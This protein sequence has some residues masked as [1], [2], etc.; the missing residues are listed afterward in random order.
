[1]KHTKRLRKSLISIMGGVL[2]LSLLLAPMFANVYAE[3]AGT[4]TVADVSQYVTN[5]EDLINGY[6]SDIKLVQRNYSN[7][8]TVYE[9]YNISKQ[10]EKNSVNVLDSIS[11]PVDGYAGW[12]AVYTNDKRTTPTLFD[13]D[14]DTQLTSSSNS[15]KVQNRNDYAGNYTI[16]AYGK[17]E[18]YPTGFYF[19]HNANTQKEVNLISFRSDCFNV[20]DNKIC[21]TTQRNTTNWMGSDNQGGYT[22]TLY[23]DQSTGHN[24]NTSD[25]YGGSSFLTISAS[26]N[27]KI[28]V[29]ET[30]TQKQVGDWYGEKYDLDQS[31][32]LSAGV[33]SD[34]I[35]D[36][37]H[38]DVWGDQGTITYLKYTYGTYG[39]TDDG[40]CVYFQL[41]NEST[42]NIVY[43]LNK[44]YTTKATNCG[45][46]CSITTHYR[47][48]YFSFAGVNEPLINQNK[49]VN[50]GT[51]KNPQWKESYDSTLTGTFNEDDAISSLSTQLPSGYKLKSTEGT[52]T[53]GKNELAATY[54]RS[55]EYYGE[56]TKTYDCT[57]TVNATA[58]PKYNITVKDLSGA[59]VVTHSVKQGENYTFATIEDREKSFIAYKD[60]QG[61]LYNVGDSVMLSADAEYTLV[62]A[63]IQ[64]D[65]KVSV[66]LFNNE[67][68]YGGLRYTAT[69]SKT[70]Y[71]AIKNPGVKLYGAIIPTDLVDGTF[72][73]NEAGVNA[74]EITQ[75]AIVEDGSNA[76]GYFTMTDIKLYNFNREFSG[77]AY[78][79][80]TYKDGDKG[81]VQ[82]SSVSASIYDLAVDAYAA[83]KQAETT[84][85]VGLYGANNVAILEHYIKSVVDL[86]YN[87]TNVSVTEETGTGL[88]ADYTISGNATISEGTVTVQIDVENSSLKDLISDGALPVSVILRNGSNPN[89]YQSVI[90]TSRS[91]SGN[92]LTITFTLPNA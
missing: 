22:F 25:K 37:R 27:G 52:L 56:K 61:K 59:S 53:G 63:N 28:T 57:I 38:P 39:E 33:I 34:W 73:C 48:H 68:G 55:Y 69:I 87:G 18:S 60:S 2:A 9:N 82:T 16:A 43:E 41:Y 24:E 91:L 65:S 44:Y 6:D 30:I 62:E 86:T 26:V 92:V 70:D 10:N 1:M 64:I 11:Q 75:D 7:Q 32:R 4:H 72:D 85:S 12:R 83:H 19:N 5:V 29:L 47:M 17:T 80:V 15:Y 79:E 40:I 50:V 21:L 3:E 77:M 84:S 51:A 58:K 71:E 13:S 74:T 20:A 36:D 89:A 90:V 23:E 76:L 35:V 14:V 67:N 88:T 81:Y 8:T 42:N 31:K 78:L 66:R 46:I 45:N 49:L 54:T